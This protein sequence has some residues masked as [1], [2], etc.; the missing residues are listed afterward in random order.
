[1]QKEVA[2]TAGISEWTV[3]RA[4]G[5]ASVRTPTARKIADAL[6]VSVSDLLESPPV[7]LASAPSASPSPDVEA[8]EA[9]PR[10]VGTALLDDP[11]IGE[12]LREN[13]LKWGA[14]DDEAFAEHV[15][16]LDLAETDEDGRHVAVMELVR[17]LTDEQ[18]K[19]K[20][21]LWIQQTNYRSLGLLLSVDP[22]A[23]VAEQKQQRRDQLSELRKGLDRRYRRRAHALERYAE[24]LARG[25]LWGQ[26]WRETAA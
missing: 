5:G 22:D 10:N 18:S 12:W 2:A 17:A 21:L 20:D 6:G 8:T 4:E 3:L 19:A 1:M 24:L 23:P 16:G 7:P 9:G 26:V 13:D 14:T 25:G 11:R 15:R